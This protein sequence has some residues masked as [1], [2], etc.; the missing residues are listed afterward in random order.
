M[1]REH[2]VWVALAVPCVALLAC[3]G[4]PEEHPGS[5]VSD[6]SPA[7]SVAPRSELSALRSYESQLRRDLDL[8]ALPGAD[9]ASGADPYQ[10]LPLDD[11]RFVGLLRGAG[12]V[13]FFDAAGKESQRLDAPRAPGAMAAGEEKLWVVS[14][15][16]REVWI[17]DLVGKGGPQPKKLTLGSPAALRG[18]VHAAGHWYAADELSSAVVR[19]DPSGS[20][21]DLVPVA[22]CRG[23]L[24]IRA[25]ERWLAAGCLL[26]HRIKLFRL[27]EGR[28]LESDATPISISSRGPFW[29]FALRESGEALEVVA[30]GV[31]DAPLDRTIG[32]FGNIDSFLYGFRVDNKGVERTG[33]LNTSAA[34]AVLP[35]ALWLDP[36]E[37][38]DSR[39][40]VFAGYASSGLFEVSWTERGFGR[41]RRMSAELPPGSR[42]L[43]RVRRSWV[44]A[45]PLLDAWVEVADGSL[46]RYLEEPEVAPIRPASTRLGEA[47]F[48]TTL[49][50]PRN[51]S[52]G[53][54]SRFTCETCHFEGYGDGRVHAT[55]RGEVT[56]TT[57][58]LLGL[59]GNRPYFTR[60]LDRDLAQ[61]VNNEFR[62]AGANSGTSPV[63]SVEIAE[64]PWLRR[65][66]VHGTKLT[67]QELR[68][69]LLDFLVHFNHRPNPHLSERPASEGLSAEEAEGA[70][71]FAEHCATCHSPRLEAAKPS[72]E[73]PLSE[74]PRALSEGTS[75]VW[76]SDGYRDTGVEPR[77]HPRGARP[78]SLRR[79]Y[80]KAPYF[81][82]GGAQDL[83]SVLE[84]CGYVG[85]RFVHQGLPAS[86]RRLT[87]PERLALERFLRLL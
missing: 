71:L 22:S 41:P 52:D 11:G 47:L 40:V 38:G 51:K 61:M 53:Q 77:V 25:T 78:S 66:G 12:E 39:R 58:P 65:L 42:D 70:G 16:Q 74:W 19:L 29:A 5:A 49:M 37:S 8:A 80:K 7:G 10:L 20:R 13:V 55:G 72:S 86:G 33:V 35:K 69:A 59:V 21:A 23:A 14:E 17:Y 18:V 27:T 9:I 44:V 46:P 56:A 75:L 82:N 64:W 26:E 28:A 24:S 54:L 87:L 62:V 3:A 4:A 32:S 48:F 84:Q 45:N 81:T 36:A 30:S 85:D 73:V 68:R 57:K 43:M 50:A 79:L 34:G 83:Q 2:M 60:G 67:A 76:A 1:G 31:E 63:F 15:L 6:A